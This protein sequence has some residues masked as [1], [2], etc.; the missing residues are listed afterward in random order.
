MV[1][2]PPTPPRQR[3]QPLQ[4][5]PGSCRDAIQ[6]RQPGDRRPDCISVGPRGYMHGISWLPHPALWWGKRP[7]NDPEFRR[8]HWGSDWWRR[9]LS[10]SKSDQIRCPVHALWSSTSTPGQASAFRTF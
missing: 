7:G 6:A 5:T 4:P 2:H 10:R 1:R 8:S 3:L 9:D